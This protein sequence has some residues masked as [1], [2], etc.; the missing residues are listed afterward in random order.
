VLLALAG[1]LVIGLVGPG[2]GK[3]LR[4][5]WSNWRHASRLRRLWTA[6]RHEVDERRWLYS[7]S[8]ARSLSVLLGSLRATGADE[9]GQRRLVLL[10]FA[11]SHCAALDEIRTHLDRLVDSPWPG[12]LRAE[13]VVQL[14]ESLI[15]VPVAAGWLRELG[16][17]DRTS[18]DWDRV[19]DW[20]TRYRNSLEDYGRWARD[21]NRS[22]GRRVF[23][24]NL[25]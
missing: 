22:L 6:F 4:G 14:F 5:V 8:D 25:V 18:G 23:R 10:Q 13:S 3:A 20:V 17:V 1:L 12:Q 19:N 16:A 24:E 21:S 9:E 15:M 7:R 11:I 2:I